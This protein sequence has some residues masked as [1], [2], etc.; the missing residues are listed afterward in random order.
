[1]RAHGRLGRDAPAVRRGPRRRGLSDRHG[2]P[3]APGDRRLPLPAMPPV[4]HLQHAPVRVDRRRSLHR[5]TAPRDCRTRMLPPE[6]ASALLD[7]AGRPDLAAVVTAAARSYLTLDEPTYYADNMRTLERS[8]LRGRTPQEGSGFGGNEIE[9]RMARHHISEGI[10][11]GG[12]FLDV[13]CANGLL[14]ESIAAWCSERDVRVEPY[15]VD[16]APGLVDLARRRLPRW[17][18]RIWLGNAID[19]IPPDGRRFDYVHILLDCVPRARSADLIRHHLQRT[20]RRGGG[21]LLVSDYAADVRHCALS[22]AHTLAALGFECCG[23]SAG[24]A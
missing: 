10:G 23:E 20:V 11:A 7:A 17:A 12:T 15:G 9:W 1:M 3:G 2:A 16:Y 19:W 5:P 22:A 4:R 18:D 13:G 24:D 14:M 6:Q 8:Y 21:R